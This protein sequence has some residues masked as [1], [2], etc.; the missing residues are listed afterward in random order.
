MESKQLLHSHPP[1][2]SRHCPSGSNCTEVNVLYDMELSPSSRSSSV[3]GEDL[4]FLYKPVRSSKVWYS[5][6]NLVLQAEDM[7][8]KVH[9]SILIQRSKVFSDMLAVTQPDNP[10][11]Q[12]VDGCEVVQL[13]DDS[14]DDMEEAL[15]AIYGDQ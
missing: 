15:R 13:R 3:L 4:T 9:R 8:F 2:S 5:D 7:L 6:G 10:L 12:L 1:L 14:G 11:E